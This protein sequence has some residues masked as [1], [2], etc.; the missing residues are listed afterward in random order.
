MYESINIIYFYINIYVE[1]VNKT[2][3]EK[4]VNTNNFYFV[5]L[6]FIKTLVQIL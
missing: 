1:F 4:T 3:S 6:Y 5:V 2:L